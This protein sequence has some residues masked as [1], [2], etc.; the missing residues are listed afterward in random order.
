MDQRAKNARTDADYEEKESQ[1]KFTYIIS[2]NGINLFQ[3][4]YN[5]IKKKIFVG[6][7]KRDFNIYEVGSNAA[8]QGP[9]IGSVSAFKGFFDEFERKQE[10][11]R[12]DEFARQ[13]KKIQEELRKKE[14]AELRNLEKIVAEEKQKR[15]RKIIIPSIIA[16]AG[17]LLFLLIA[18]GLWLPVLIGIGVIA[19]IVIIFLFAA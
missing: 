10:K 9:E 8:A 3:C 19:V 4:T 12:Q 18:T 1:D 7:I 17:V 11:L 14:N 5:E 2:S 13:E 6:E 16:G 15:N